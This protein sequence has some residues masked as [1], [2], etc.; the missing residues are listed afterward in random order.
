MALR[1]D[2]WIS[3]GLAIL[4]LVVI[5]GLATVMRYEALSNLIAAQEACGE[6]L[7]GIEAHLRQQDELLLR[8]G[9]GKP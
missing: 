9:Q 8:R 7:D 2:E 6:R 4:V 3:L 5:V 1:R